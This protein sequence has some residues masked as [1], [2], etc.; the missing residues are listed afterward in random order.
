M[1]SFVPKHKSYLKNSDLQYAAK[2]TKAEQD[3][4]N[5]KEKNKDGFDL[6]F[7]QVSKEQRQLEK[8]DRAIKVKIDCRRK[9]KVDDQV[10]KEQII[11]AA[12]LFQSLEEDA[13][14][15]QL[16]EDAQKSEKMRQLA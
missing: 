10:N 9:K 3:V 6:M 8:Q 5:E 2:K 15:K 7:E 13:A 14:V 12:A 16:I 1:H 4:I 11:K